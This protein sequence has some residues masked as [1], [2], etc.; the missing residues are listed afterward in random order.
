[1]EMHRGDTFIYSP[2]DALGQTLV[3]ES[4]SEPPLPG[5]TGGSRTREPVSPNRGRQIL[6]AN[7][8]VIDLVDTPRSV[9][10]V[11]PPSAVV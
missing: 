10:F 8:G 5:N 3:A 11:T 9:M 6:G 1:V 2:Q 4:R 7:C